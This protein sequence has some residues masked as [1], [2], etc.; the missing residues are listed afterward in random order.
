[1]STTYKAQI[2]D[3]VALLFRDTFVKF[4]EYCR[5][6]EDFREPAIVEFDREVQFYLA[7][8]EHL[9]PQET[10]AELLLSPPDRDARRN[11]RL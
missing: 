4:D 1:M 11:I 6:N 8:L 7:Y 5:L 2:L 3:R 10:G 9:A